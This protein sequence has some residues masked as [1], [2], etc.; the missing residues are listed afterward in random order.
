[1]ERDRVTQRRRETCSQLATGPVPVGRRLADESVS[2]QFR[3]R[4]HKPGE[5]ISR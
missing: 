5:E 3:L 2:L 1:M 4:R